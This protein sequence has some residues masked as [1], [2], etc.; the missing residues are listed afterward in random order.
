M[1]QHTTLNISNVQKDLDVQTVSMDL[2]IPQCFKGWAL[3]Q[4][5]YGGGTFDQEE[6]CDQD[7]EE[8]D[9]AVVG[10]DPKDEE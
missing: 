8:A 2:A 7:L 5:H 1:E 9:Q 4:K 10:W 6:A 3:R